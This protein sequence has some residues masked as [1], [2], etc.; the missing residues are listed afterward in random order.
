MRFAVYSIV[1][2]T[3]GAAEFDAV[4]AIFKDADMAEERVRY[5]DVPLNR[6]V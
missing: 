6:P 4:L 3:G 2:A 5:D 1:V